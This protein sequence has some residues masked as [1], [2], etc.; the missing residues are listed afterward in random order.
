MQPDE[1]NDLPCPNCGRNLRLGST[2]PRFFCPSC[3]EELVRS[4]KENK[5]LLVHPLSSYL[6]GAGEDEQAIERWEKASADVVLINLRKR[7]G[8]LEKSTQ[9]IAQRKALEGKVMKIGGG[10]LLVCALFLTFAI[11]RIRTTESVQVDVF[12][13]FIGASLVGPFGIF[14]CGWG[15]VERWSWLKH[16]AWISEERRKVQEEARILKAKD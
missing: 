5:L 15:L 6:D 3:K 7:Q 11:V 9:W 16:A 12:V 2:Q 13:S 1:S 14:F 4:V 10:L 8:T